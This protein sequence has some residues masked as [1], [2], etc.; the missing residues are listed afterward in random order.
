[1]DFRPDWRNML[2]AVKNERPKR[3][4]IY[5]HL[6][7]PPIMEKIL[8]VTFAGSLDTDTHHFF[9]NYCRFWKEMTYDT[10]SYEVC[11]TEILPDGGAIRGGKK[12]PIQSRSDFESY[13]WDE[14]PGRFWAIAEPR[15]EALQRCMPEG[16]K[17]VGGIGNGPFEISEDL[18]GYEYLCY[19]Q[20][21]DPQLFDD[22]YKKIGDLLA[23]IWTKFLHK[24]DNLYAV[25]RFGDDLGFKG[26][27]LLN[28]A[29][30]K[31]QVIPQYRR[32]IDLVHKAGKPFLLHSCGCIFEV[33]DE[34]IA[35]GIDAKHSNEDVI[36]PFD[37]WLKRYN[38]KIGLLGGIDLD[39][40]CQAKPDAVYGCVLESGTRYRQNSNGFALGSGNSIPDYVPVDGYLAMIR[41]AQEIRRLETV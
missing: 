37:E 30:V 9:D 23:D 17:A 4:P 5:E 24:Y 29:A 6:I 41:A 40:L 8:G 26:G 27:T 39:L 33:M 19:M 36:A 13:P 38:N 7:D 20:L 31:A 15:F 35:A 11:I 18:V 22:L 3:L 32:I 10:V 1:M 2:A 34:I 28:P 14:L 16:M 12:G 21:D 25:C